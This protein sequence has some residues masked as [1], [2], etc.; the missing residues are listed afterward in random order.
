MSHPLIGITSYG[1][2]TKDEFHLYANYLE[3]VRLAGGVPVLLTPGEAHPDVLLQKLDGIVFSGGGDI[4]PE[5]FGGDPHPMIYSLDLER[6]RFE[7]KL[8]RQVLQAAVPAMGICRGLQVLNVA[9][10]GDKLIPHVPDIFLDIHHR[11]EPPN[12]QTR[13]QPTRHSV[14]VSPNSRLAACVKAEQITVV[15]WHHQAIKTPP[16]SWQI[17][18]QAPDGLIE[19]IERPDHPWLLALQWHPE[20]AIADRDQLSIFQAFIAAAAGYS[21]VHI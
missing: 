19:A 20:M 21:K 14:N 9:S 5:C 8:A 10:G 17:V 13:A 7:L 6:D 2:N 4:S 12:V 3:A 1:R 15:S 18:A 16:P 11:L